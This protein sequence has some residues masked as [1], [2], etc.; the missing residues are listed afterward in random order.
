MNYHRAIPL[1]AGAFLVA[2]FAFFAAQLSPGMRAEGTDWAMYVMHARNIVKGLP[3]THT[4]YV[5][6]P[7]STTEVG[8]NS[9]PSGYPLLLAPFYAACG[10]NIQ[11]F[12]LLNVAFLVLSLWPVYCY[13]R[14]DLP[15]VHSLLLIVALGLSALFFAI[16]DTIGSDALYQLVSFL[17]L[18][19]LLRIS[20]RQLQ[21]AGPWK[22]GLLAGMGAAAAYL[23]RPFG[24]ALF[25]AA[26]G[27]EWMRRRRITR[28]LAAMACAFF[29]LVLANNLFLHRDAS[30][31]RQFTC[32]IPLV[33]SHAAA[34]VGFLS[35]V[36]AN[37]VSHSFRY[38]LWAASLVLAIAAISQRVRSAPAVVE[39]YALII[40]A[41]VG[42]YWVPS[43]RYLLGVMPVYMV[44]VL[45]GFRMLVARFPALPWRPLQAGAA[46]L[47][48]LA[49][50]ANALLVRADPK[51]TLVTSPD[52]EALCATIR[53]QTAAA[54][55]VVFWNP[56][57]LA[58]STGR[59]A[60]GWPAA[61]PPERTVSYLGRV[62]PDYIV[63]D[64]NRPDDR[65]F[66]IPLVAAAP[67]RFVTVYENRQ[68]VLTSVVDGPK[69]KAPE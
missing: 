53:R 7:E 19:L 42:F 30:Y 10:L 60:S 25:L 28:F 31:A 32:S 9:Y 45:R 54:S 14:R 44:L 24:L 5:F 68:F 48:L 56:R 65:R 8:A 47:L 18:L 17:V 41:V 58:F 34:Y 1:A 55:L 15:Q 43:P 11:L 13:A 40:L 49:P 2:L 63:T 4:G 57:V 66:L 37:P 52:Y 16:F 51:D 46:I 20:D 3:Y 27:S 6:Q 22:W 23:V 38:V 61:P 33:L 36:F 29:P 50:A 26:A 59:Q 35:Y 21:E 67:L 69:R 39:L 62:R 64:K 12:K